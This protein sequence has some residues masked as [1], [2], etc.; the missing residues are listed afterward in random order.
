MRQ[1]GKLR[2]FVHAEKAPQTSLDDKDL[3]AIVRIGNDAVSNYYEIKIPL[4][5]TDFFETDS[6]KIWPDVNN[7]DFDLKE[8]TNLKTRRNRNG[9][10]TSQYYRETTADGRSFAIIGNPN[11]GEV[12]IMLMAV[13][14]VGKETA[15]AE[16]WFNELRFSDL[17]ERGGYAGII[18]ADLKLADLG[19]INFSGTVKSS[20]FGTLEQRVNERSREDLYTMDISANIDGGKLLPKKLGIQIPVYAGY[21]RLTS[22]PEYDP[23]ALDL[24]SKDV[25]KDAPADKRD[26]IKSESQTVTS[27]KTIN[28]TNVKKIKT[29]GKRPMPWSATNLDF[30]YSYIET[31]SHDPL[32]ESDLLRRTRGAIAYNYSPQVKP[33]EP[34]KKMIKSTSKWLALIKEFNITPAPSQISIRAD[35]FRQ[36]GADTGTK[37]RR[38]SL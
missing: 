21:S 34:F 2:M 23:L 13:E 10:P 30:N 36:F 6:L 19:M 7:L 32:I 1:Y 29:D 8:L 25:I 28:L 26:S 20:G 5:L 16:V 11:L 24:K 31:Q 18:R 9:I 12:R 27:I 35:A 14:N 37:C 17:D 4:K 38:R 3:N 22:N 33:F 15:C